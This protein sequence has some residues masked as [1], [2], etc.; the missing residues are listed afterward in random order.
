MIEEILQALQAETVVAG[1]KAYVHDNYKIAPEPT[2]RPLHT[3][4]LQSVIDVLTAKFEAEHAKDL[5]IYIS[6]PEAVSL[7]SNSVTKDLQRH[8]LVDADAYVF[9]F[10]FGTEYSYESFIIA[11]N[12]QFQDN[13]G[14]TNLLKA[15]SQIS[16]K[17]ENSLSDTGISQ[18]FK[19]KAGITTSVKLENPIE[20]IPFRTF[21]EVEQPASLFVFR[22]LESKGTVR[23]ILQEAGGSQWKLEAI[24]HIRQWFEA[25]KLGVPIIG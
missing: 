19:A 12:S 14:K 24:K 5:L 22:M 2:V 20:L 18:E 16:K 21:P 17:V 6:S 11:L 15:L 4:T 13:P 7:I 8:C 25:Q 9:D 3:H 1:N 10:Y 23:L